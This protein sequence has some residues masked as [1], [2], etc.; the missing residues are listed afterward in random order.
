MNFVKASNPALN[1]G[2]ILSICKT[3]F[4]FQPLQDHLTKYGD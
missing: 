2:R 1:S 3:H 4:T